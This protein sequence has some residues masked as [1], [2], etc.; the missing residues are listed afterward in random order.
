MDQKPHA[1]RFRG[2]GFQKSSAKAGTHWVILM[3]R[4]NK[5]RYINYRHGVLLEI[6]R[7][8]VGFSY[9]NQ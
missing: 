1:A 2:H 5:H 6:F 4:K 7:F 9:K 8:N 3:K